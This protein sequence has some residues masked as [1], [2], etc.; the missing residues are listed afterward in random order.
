MLNKYIQTVPWEIVAV[1][2]PA[3]CPEHNKASLVESPAMIAQDQESSAVFRVM[4]VRMLT[5]GR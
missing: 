5:N 1:K 2:A 4:V 3:G